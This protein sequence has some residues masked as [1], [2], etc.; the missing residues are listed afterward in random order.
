MY[1]SIAMDDRL[2]HKLVQAREHFERGEL[3]HA[4][5]LL[6]Q[7]LEKADRFAD[8]HNML[9]IVRHARGDFGAARDAFERAVTINP[10]YTEALLN[11]VVTCNDMGD[12][13]AGRA[14]YDTVRAT[15][16]PS[17][18]GAVRDP[19]ALGKIA[20]MHSEVAQAYADAG[21]LDEAVAELRKA[22]ALR[23]AF[24]D[25]HVKLGTFLR[26]RGDLEE[27]R[28]SFEAAT[29]ANPGYAAAWVQ[30]GITLYMLDR[31]DEAKER[32]SRALELDP[33]HKIASMYLRLV[34]RGG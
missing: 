33:K 32:F 2:K 4:E 13:A 21:Y 20:N 7:V 28:A 10:H 18:E 26:D 22:V 16:Q 17:D 24:S 23:P 12:Y 1:S 15:A 25:L 14:F 11:L 5:P 27:A 31:K 19:Y 29:A 9:G 34:E 8:L 3:E 6:L 30:L